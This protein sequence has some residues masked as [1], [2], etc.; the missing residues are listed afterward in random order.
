MGDFKFSINRE[1]ERERGG[2]GVMEGMGMCCEEVEKWGYIYIV[3][4]E[5][6][7]GLYE[8]TDRLKFFKCEP[9]RGGE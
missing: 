2:G 5:G 3:T 7:S 9:K 1:R 6:L 4:K 8:E